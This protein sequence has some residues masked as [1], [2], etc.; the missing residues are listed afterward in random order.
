[1]SQ[2]RVR[3]NKIIMC[4]P[5]IY[6]WRNV[7]RSEQKHPVAIC[8]APKT[9]VTPP[10]FGTIPNIKVTALQ[11]AVTCRTRS[12]QPSALTE[13]VLLSRS[14]LGLETKTETLAFKYRDRDQDLGHQVS[15]PRPRPGQNE[16]ECTR[17]SKSHHWLH[18]FQLVT[19]HSLKGATNYGN[20]ATGVGTKHAV[21]RPRPR[22]GQN[23][24]ECT[25]VS[26]PWSRDHNTAFYVHC[27][28]CF[29]SWFHV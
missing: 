1:M 8:L 25:R 6:C 3:K 7:H 10:S 14:F 17:V 24:L 5:Y 27:V 26:S 11:E 13:A 12:A 15:R 22:P 29:M 2:L 18:Q 23:E 4:Q 9:V 20:R 21:L 19:E 16:L 28:N